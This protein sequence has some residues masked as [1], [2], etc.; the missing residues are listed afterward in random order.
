MEQ[1]LVSIVTPSFNQARF[2]E[3]ALI[4]VARQTYPRVEH[5]VVDG[6]SSDGSVEIIR[7]HADRLAWWVS[8][9]DKGQA[10]AINKGMR[11]ARGE[12][13]AWL[14]SD[15]AL[16]PWAVAEAV[17]EFARRP[18]AVLVFGDAL[19]FNAEGR[20]F[21]ILRAGNW[22]LED[23]MTFHILPQPA[24][25]MRREA[26]EAVGFLDDDFHYLLDHKLWLKLALKGEMVYR[27]RVWAFARYHEAAK[28]AAQAAKFGDEALRLAEW[29]SADPRFAAPYARLR[30]RVWA[31]AY[32]FRARYLLDAGK[33]AAALRSYLRA[34]ALH[35]PSVKPEANRVLFAALSLLGMGFLR[36]WYYRRAW[37]KIPPEAQA[38]GIEN[39]DEFV[40]G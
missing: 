20:P 24:V 6:G 34:F 35:P 27:R 38:L 21:H 13:V 22:G 31:A 25:F 17:E 36:G 18:A 29:M 23:L 19:S 39:V 15:D 37:G 26:A 16:A 28:N 3:T 2:L 14:N 4:S 32:R 40:R 7:R 1:P 12:I 9:P 5:L 8:E 30:R 33:S 11:R 10:D